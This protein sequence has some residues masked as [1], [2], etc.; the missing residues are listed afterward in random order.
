MSHSSKIHAGGDAL[1]QAGISPDELRAQLTGTVITPEHPQYDELRGMFYGGFDRHPALIVQAADAQDVARVISLARE[2]GLPLAIRSGG[3]SVAGFSVIDDGIVLDMRGMKA[4]D[5]DPEQRTAWAETGLT[6]GEYTEAAAKHGLATGFGD[7]GSVGI[8]GITLGGGVGYFVR[9]T[10]LTID[11]LLAAEI[12]TAD[13][14]IRYV[15]ADNHPDLFWAIRGGGGNFGVVTRF[16]FRLHPVDKIYGG[17]LM[18]PVTEDILTSFVAEAE[19]APEELSALINVMVAPPMPMIP[20]EH[21]GK[22]MLFALMAY[23]GDPEAGETAMAPFRALA[24]P[25]ADMLKPMTY[26]EMFMEEGGDEEYHPKAV[27]RTMFINHFDRSTAETFLEQIQ[28]SDAPMRVAHVRV[29][30]GAMARVPAD[31]TAFAHRQSKMMVNIAA[32]YDTPEERESR[33]RWAADFAAKLH[34]GDDGQYV[35]FIGPEGDASS[36]RNAYPGDTWDRLRAVKAK[37]DP[38]NLFSANHNIPPAD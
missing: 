29:L 31:A 36:A 17:M 24:E 22:L 25:M 26:P 38:T 12:V 30:G 11:D 15:D 14:E 6:T 28:Q 34:Q 32:F 10:G 33:D 13:G 3:H 19:A 7:T 5:I 23:I 4:L 9:K 8:G 35:N 2:S 16:K 27:S 1:A 37:Y 18:L 21:Q 20:E